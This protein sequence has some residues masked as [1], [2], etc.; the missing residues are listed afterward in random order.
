MPGLTGLQVIG[1]MRRDPEMASIPVI[2]SSVTDGPSKEEAKR[3][4]QS[5]KFRKK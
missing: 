4:L 5:K 3:M 2:L 1:A